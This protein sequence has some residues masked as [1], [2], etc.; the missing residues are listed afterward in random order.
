MNKPPEDWGLVLNAPLVGGATTQEVVVWE[1]T[2]GQGVS[3]EA[4]NIFSGAHLVVPGST[5]TAGGVTG[6]YP[7]NGVGL[8]CEGTP[9]SS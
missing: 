6:E 2:T 8:G 5:D 3:L 9:D 1:D 4:R 7:G